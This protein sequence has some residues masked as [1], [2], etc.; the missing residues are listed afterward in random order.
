MDLEAKIASYIIKAQVASDSGKGIHT[1]L[2]ADN[3]VFLNETQVRHRACYHR[4]DRREVILN[5]DDSTIYL[6]DRSELGLVFTNPDFATKAERFGYSEKTTYILKA[7]H[8]INSNRRC[9]WNYWVKRTADQNGYSSVITYFEY[10]NDDGGDKLQISF[11]TPFS[12]SPFELDKMAN[13]KKGRVCH[14]DQ[15]GS[16]KNCQILIDKFDF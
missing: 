5:K 11:H 4:E 10:K 2:K 8:L 14:W 12:K 13:K 3:I 9:G 15:K 7:L 16:R 6:N 1:C